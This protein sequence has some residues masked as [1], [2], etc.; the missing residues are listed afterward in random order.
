[1]AWLKL[2]QRNLGPILDA[3]G[4]AL[5]ANARINVPFGESLTRV[6]T[7]PQGSRVDMLDPY[8]EK[9]APWWIAV[10]V[11]AAFAVGWYFVRG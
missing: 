6:A 7:L 3:N 9:G 1:V 4:W 5:N 10:V 8:A 2:R 11:V